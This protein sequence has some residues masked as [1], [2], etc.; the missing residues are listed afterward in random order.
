[1]TNSGSITVDD[2]ALLL[3][4]GGDTVTGAGSITVDSGGMLSL[5][6]ADTISGVTLTV[7]SGGEVTIASGASVTFDNVVV[8][9]DATSQTPP[10]IDVA[11]GAVLTLQDSTSISGSGTGTL[12]VEAGAQLL[13]ATPSGATLNGIIVDDDGTGSSAGAGGAGIY[14]SGAVLTLDGGTQ[15]EGG[16]AAAGTLQIDRA[17]Q[18]KITGAA[19]LDSVTVTDGNLGGAGIDVSGAVL[20]LDDGTLISG[21]T[22]T[23]E[24]AS[25]SQLLVTAGPGSA[26]DGATAGGATLDA[27]SVADNS[28]STANPGIEVASGA[29]LTLDGG[30][31]ITGV[32]GA[33]MT[34]AGILEVDNG[35]DSI[36]NVT[37]TD[38]GTNTNPA[39]LV[40]SGGTLTLNNDLFNGGAIEI[41]SMLVRRLFSIAPISPMQFSIPRPVA[42]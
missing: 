23:V 27:V 25:G 12:A 26:S 42:P 11:S 39:Q 7:E 36:S 18:L 17:G 38:V 30:T 41:P 16:A 10:G 32:P 37:V 35:S 31:A 29:V 3:L 6:G 21:G 33:T 8:T 28:T 4:N 20:T 5:S 22:L 2:N 14:V 9:D 40:V 15:I 34:L 13:I 24:S 19:T 1:M